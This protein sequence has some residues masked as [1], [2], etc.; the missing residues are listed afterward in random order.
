MNFRWLIGALL[1]CLL[2]GT[3]VYAA[4][5]GDILTPEEKGPVVV[6]NYEG[7]RTITD[8]ISVKPVGGKSIVLTE[9]T[10][11]IMKDVKYPYTIENTEITILKYECTNE[12]CGYWISATRDGK[13]VATNSPVWISSPPYE[14]VISNIYYADLNEKEPILD[15]EKAVLEVVTLKEDP[16]GAIE[17]VLIAYCDRQPLGKGVSYE[18]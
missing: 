3:V 18:R 13:E 4:D 5:L 17:Q 16:K 10:E 14:I 8:A 7:S 1:V 9:V 15:A 12:I 6:V 2:V 11:T